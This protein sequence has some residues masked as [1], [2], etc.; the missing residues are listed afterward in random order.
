MALS[1]R[2]WREFSSPSLLVKLFFALW[3]AE[4][5]GRLRTGSSSTIGARGTV[6]GAFSARSLRR[7]RVSRQVKV[8]QDL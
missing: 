6:A 1:V 2:D 4:P 7:R 5:S 3:R 8:I